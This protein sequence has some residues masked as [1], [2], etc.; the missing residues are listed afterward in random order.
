LKVAIIGAGPAGITAAR[1]LCVAG[2]Q[3]VVFEKEKQV[4]GLSRTIQLW[5]QKVDLGPHRF[6][7]TYPNVRA[8]WFHAIGNDYRL[9]NRQTRIF[10][11]GG[12]FDYPLRPTNVVR[13]LGLTDSVSCFLSYCGQQ[14]APHHSQEVTFESWVSQR[15]G[16]QLYEKFFKTYS[17]KLWGIPCAELDADFAVQRIRSF[18]LWEALKSAVIPKGGEHRTL[19]DEFAYPTGGAGMVYE[20]MATEIQKWGG[21][22][23]TGCSVQAVIRDNNVIRGVEMSDGSCE[24]FDHVISTM[25]L[26]VLLRGFRPLPDA[27]ETASSQLTYRNTI[28]VYL[29]IGSKQLFPDQWIYVH[30]PD[31]AVGR[32]T[33]FRN[34]VPELCSD[35]ST[36]VVALEYWCYDNDSS[37]T[38]PDGQLVQQA[39]E[40]FRAS[41]LLGSS[42]VLNGHVERIRGSYPVYR[43]GYKATLAPIIGF[44]NEMR[45]LTVIGR[46]G[47]FKYNNQ[48]HSMLMGTM[49]A[50]NVL[51]GPKHNL[52]N[53]NTDSD[54]Q[55]G[56]SGFSL[57]GS[58]DSQQRPSAKTA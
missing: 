13:N 36:S 4:G 56:G 45:N 9:I 37:W 27:V 39:M 43:I 12:F 25:D 34:W 14:V 11:R 10:Y 15:F 18:N 17:E 54:Y 24:L 46:S 33:N 49:A 47:S 30:S 28:L 5:G 2:E 7:T 32:I 22:I 50:E 42:Q 29:Q 1:Q 41:G 6:F 3:V 51:F 40:E 44:L 53:V 38:A 26:P 21:E 8:L 20:R 19:V 23:R 48:D 52:W 58:E 57:S 31:L 16:H 55:E 35:D